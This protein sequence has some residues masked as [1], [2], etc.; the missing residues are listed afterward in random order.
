MKAMVSGLINVETNVRVKGFP[1]EYFPID[2]PFFGVEQSVGGVGYNISKALST[3]GDEVRFY[4]FTGDDL[5]AR[6]IYTKLKDNH[7]DVSHVNNTLKATPA[8]VALYDA[9]GKRQIYCDLKDVQEQM[10]EECEVLNEVDICILCNTNF[11]RKLLKLAKEAGK[12]IATDVHVLSDP[13]DEYNKD[14]MEYADILFLSNEKVPGDEES[15][16]VKLSE[17]YSPQ[18]IVMGRGSKGIIYYDR[19]VGNVKKMPAIQLGK[20]VNTIGAGDALFS[21][22]LHFYIKGTDLDEALMKAQIFAA[23]KI[24]SNG[25]ANGFVTE[26]EIEE[27]WETVRQNS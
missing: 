13:E 23:K 11:N 6:G 24:Q 10:I 4:S 3:L 7:I 18:V 22:F 15:F 19:K 20:V 8:S 27:A 17:K 1:I 2:Y 26:K 14:F 5:S 9:N 25:A 21:S 16:L 12:M